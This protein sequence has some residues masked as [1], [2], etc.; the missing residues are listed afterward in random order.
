MLRTAP[1]K[2]GPRRASCPLAHVF[3]CAGL[4]FALSGCRD[5]GPRSDEAAPPPYLVTIDVGDDVRALALVDSDEDDD[6]GQAALR[7][8]RALGP[9]ARDALIASLSREPEPARL[10]AID[11]LGDIAAGGD[12]TARAALARVAR[13]APEPAV[14]AAAITSLADLG[15]ADSAAAIMAALGDG[16]AA[17]RVAAAGVCPGACTSDASLEALAHMAIS[18]PNVGHALAAFQVLKRLRQDPALSDATDRA[19]RRAGESVLG[20]FGT[21]DVDQ[22]T[23]L[24]MAALLL[25]DV[26]DRRGATVLLTA[27]RALPA[28]QL[29]VHVIRALGVVGDE[30][31]VAALAALRGDGGVGAVAA[32]SLRSLADRGVPGARDAVEAPLVPAAPQPRR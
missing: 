25:A 6:R 3:L 29:R 18:E 23:S 15:T 17:V 7:R 9:A 14:R 11:L 16:D 22:T 12:A 32:E 13:E 4:A 28:P 20:Y 21:S 19:A 5:S 31:A 27:L 26:G 24:V 30:K 2:P 10:A 8:L 1:C